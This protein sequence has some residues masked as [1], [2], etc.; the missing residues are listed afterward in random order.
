MDVFDSNMIKEIKNLIINSREIL[1]PLIDKHLK[2][3][4]HN[5]ERKSLELNFFY[6]ALNVITKKWTVQILMELEVHGPM[7]FNELMRHLEGISSRSL[8]DAL[9]KLE[10]YKLVL[11]SVQDT[12]PPSVL[13]QLTNKGKGLVEISLLLI[14]QLIDI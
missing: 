11:R 7:I 9:K 3:E 10:K 5:S 14:I 13:Y 8:S 4:N 2:E 6:K 12:R 1:K